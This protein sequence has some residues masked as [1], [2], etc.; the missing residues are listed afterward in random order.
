MSADQYKPHLLLLPEDKANRDLANGFLLGI[1]NG[2]SPEGASRARQFQVLGFPGGW[3]K[4]VEE[5]GETHIASMNRF[6]LRYMILLIDFDEQKDRLETLQKNIPDELKDRVFVI[7]VWSEPEKLKSGRGF[8]YEVI[9]TALAKECRDNAF[10]LWN[11]ELLKHNADEVERM[12]VA[13]KPLF[14][15]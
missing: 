12:R 1:A 11:H 10:N 4:V 13:L 3:G 2:F 14:F 7:G 9:G 15:A 8:S 5:F 6:P